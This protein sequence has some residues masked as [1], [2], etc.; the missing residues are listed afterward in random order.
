MWGS[1]IFSKE[2][3]DVEGHTNKYG[4]ET[5][6]KSLQPDLTKTAV[7]DIVNL[8][9]NDKAFHLGLIILF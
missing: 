6:G 9:Y 8:A 1:L 5:G 7:P 3:L 4:N 2:A